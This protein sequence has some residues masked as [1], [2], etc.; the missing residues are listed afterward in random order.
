MWFFSSPCYIHSHI[1]TLCLFYPSL[2]IQE[3]K[4]NVTAEEDVEDDEDIPDLRVLGE[5][6]EKTHIFLDRANGIALLNRHLLH[7]R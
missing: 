1:N 7:F 3:E 2:V 4:V 5:N 6:A